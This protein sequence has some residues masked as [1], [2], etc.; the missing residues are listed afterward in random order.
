[1]LIA[2]MFVPAYTFNPQDITIRRINHRRYTMRDIG[3]IAGRLDNIEYYTALSLLERDAESFEVTDEEGKNRFK[4]GFMVDNFTGH[5]VG[6]TVHRDY[7]NSMDI[8]NGELRPAHRSKGINL[9]ED[10][11]TD[12]VR[13]SRGY[14]KTGDLITLP[15]TNEVVLDQPLATRLERVN[16]FLTATW[17][18]QVNLTPSSDIWFE[19]DV[20]PD[21]IVN[22]EGDYEKE[23]ILE[24]F[25]THGKLNGQVLLK[26]QWKHLMVKL[27]ELGPQHLQLR[28][29]Y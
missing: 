2:T 24:L 19:T 1:M 6:D 10:T 26:H 28:I 20:L 21:L 13:T 5:R 8:E 3:K 23:I 7:N 9:V 14:Q 27:L 22:V 12:S 29:D 17:I 16:P 25:G 15:Y 18:G 11:T 4:C